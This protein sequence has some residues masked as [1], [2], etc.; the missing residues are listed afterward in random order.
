[1][2]AIWRAVQPPPYLLTGPGKKRRTPAT[3]PTTKRQAMQI[4]KATNPER[5]AT[6]KNNFLY[7]LQI[8]ED[9]TY[10]VIKTKLNGKPVS[11]CEI[12][13]DGEKMKPGETAESILIDLIK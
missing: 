4:I 2:G 1:M 8:E 12:L 10:N 9:K 7:L 5:Y 13:I 3:S 6:Q 11:A